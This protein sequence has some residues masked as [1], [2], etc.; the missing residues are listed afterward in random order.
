MKIIDIH[1]KKTHRPAPANT[2]LFVLIGLC[3]VFFL[4]TSYLLYDYLQEKNKFSLIRTQ[5]NTKVLRTSVEHLDATLKNIDVTAQTLAEQMTTQKTTHEQLLEQL[6]ELITSSEY[7]SSAAIAYEPFAYQKDKKLFSAQLIKDGQR[8]QQG[9]IEQFYDYTRSS[10]YMASHT[11]KAQW[12]EPYFDTSVN[13][14]IARFITPFFRFDVH[15]QARKQLGVITLDIAVERLQELVE[16]IGIGK[17]SYAIMVSSNGTLLAH[18]SYDLVLAQKTI[19]DL[20]R[21]AG[22]RDLFVMGNNIIRGQTGSASFY[23]ANAQKTYVGFYQPIPSTNWS[24]VIISVQKESFVWPIILRRKLIH[25]MLALLMLL[26]FIFTMLIGAYDGRTGKLWTMSAIF[27]LLITALVGFIWFVDLVAPAHIGAETIAN[28]VELDRFLTLHKRLNP[29]I[30]KDKSYM[31]PTGIFITDIGLKGKDVN[32]NGYVWQKY[33]TKKHKNLDQGTIFLNAQDTN[34]RESFV[35]IYEE[36]TTDEH[37]TGWRFQAALDGNFV[38]DK[39]PFDQQN[40][41]LHLSHSNFDKN[42]ILTPDFAAF[43]PTDNPYPELDPKLPLDQWFKQYTS[44]FYELTNFITD[45]GIEGYTKQKGFPVLSLAIGIR[46]KF[47]NPLVAS[48]IPIIIIM[49]ILFTNLLSVSISKEDEDQTLSV[50]R[51]SSAIFFAAA[52]AHQTFKRMVGAVAITYFEYYY[53]VL[54]LAILLVVVN[55]LLY[56]RKVPFKFIRYRKNLIPK[57]SYWPAMLLIF[58]ALTLNYFY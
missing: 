39:Y 34:K 12:L 17:E 25:F 29:Q 23:D 43:M 3:T 9:T 47:L 48:V 6:K 13:K 21:A 20:A 18:P 50:L 28:K 5:Q 22:K 33:H 7:I 58:L 32:L 35:K 16:A 31:L 46:R 44:V 19:F 54:Y 37:T 57:L 42:I 41:M 45:F 53:F 56:T 26:L 1:T 27:S 2:K 36:K 49:F 24:L 51:L 15:T 52:I 10:W 30:Y 11:G 40:I 14:L 55:C 38:Y 4:L 8:T